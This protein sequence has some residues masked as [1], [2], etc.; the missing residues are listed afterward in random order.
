VQRLADEVVAAARAALTRLGL[1]REAVEVLLGSGLLRAGDQRLQGAILEGLAEV[2]ERISVH[3]TDA[4]P[5][6]GSALLGLD[7][8]S[9]SEVAK[10]RVRRELTAAVDADDDLE[11]RRRLGMEARRG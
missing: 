4:P 1:E 5:V 6:V 11:P 3:T 7:R 2:G 9:V 8:L 10:E